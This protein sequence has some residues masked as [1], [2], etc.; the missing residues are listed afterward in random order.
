MARSESRREPVTRPSVSEA[1]RRILAKIDL[2][3]VLGQ[4]MEEVVS[5]LGLSDASVLLFDEESGELTVAVG[6]RADRDTPVPGYRLKVG[7]GMI[8][9][10]ALTR[11][12]QLANDV[13]KNPHFIRDFSVMTQSELCLPMI[14]DA[15]LLGVLDLQSR[16]P[17]AFTAAMLPGL[18]AFAEEAALAVEHATLYQNA[19]DWSQR[20]EALLNA[21]D[22]GILMTDNDRHIQVANLKCGELLGVD[23]AWLHGRK[24]PTALVERL[25]ERAVDP[26]KLER[27]LVGAFATATRTIK[28]EIDLGQ[29]PETTYSL[30]STPV[31]DSKGT[32][33][34]RL[35]AIR[36][37]SNE[38]R[39]QAHLKAAA[40]AALALSSSLD[41]D[42]VLE[43]LGQA[44]GELVP[45]D[46]LSLAVIDVER[47]LFRPT[48]VQGRRNVAFNDQD[49][50]PLEGTRV[51]RV[52]ET[53]VPLLIRDLDAGPQFA[54]DESLRA[55][56]LRCIL[57]LPLVFGESCL[58]TL[59][60]ASVRPEAYDDLA[61][62]VLG[63]I[64]DNLAVAVNNSLMHE[65]VRRRADQSAALNWLIR[66]VT[67]APTLEA[68][69]PQLAAAVSEVF[70]LD[71]LSLAL[72]SDGG[73]F[74]VIAAGLA[75]GGEGDWEIRRLRLPFAP[76]SEDQAAEAA[77]G[78]PWGAAKAARITARIE[79]NGR[80]L[81]TLNLSRAP[82]PEFSFEESD[83]LGRVAAQ[84]AG[85]IENSRLYEKVREEAETSTALLEVARA[86]ARR[87]DLQEVYSLAATC[88]GRA[89]G[90]RAFLVYLPEPD[91]RCS[92]LAFWAGP[93]KPDELAAMER[94]PIDDDVVNLLGS[95]DLIIVP[96]PGRHKFK[97]L[98]APLGPGLVAISSLKSGGE[99]LGALIISCQT[100]TRLTDKHE[101]MIKG[102]AGQIATAVQEAK[103]RGKLERKVS[104]LT[105][106]SRASHHLTAILDLPVLLQEVV[107]FLANELGYN[108]AGLFLLDKEAE[109]IHLEAKAGNLADLVPDGY[110]QS[111]NLGLT[112]WAV[113]NAKPLVS[114]GAPHRTEATGPRLLSKACMCLPLVVGPEVLGVLDLES[115]T[116]GVFTP[117]EVT[118]IDILARQ[119]AIAI[120]N[121]NIFRRERELYLSAVKTLAEAVDARDHHTRAH[122]TRVAR[123]AL[124]IAH[125]LDLPVEQLATVEY[126]GLLHDIGKIGLDDGILRKKG[127]LDPLERAQM[128]EHPTKGANILQQVAAFREIVPLVKHHHEWFA[129]GGYPDGLS[130]PAIPLGARVLAVADA[131]DAMTTDRPYRLGLTPEEAL[132]RLAAGSGTQ[133]DP[134]IVGAFSARLRKLKEDQDPAYVALA[135][136]IHEEAPDLSEDHAGAAIG[137]ILPVHGKELGILYQISLET[138]SLLNLSHLMHRILSILY[139]AMGPNAYTLLLTEPDSGDLVVK[140]CV[141]LSLEGQELRVQKGVGITGW[142]AEH[143]LPQVIGD[144]RTDARYHWGPNT[145]A[146]SALA[147][148]LVVEGRTIG[149]LDI[150]SDQLNAF[151]RDDLY[152]LSAV[153]G[154]ISIAIEVA[155]YHEQVAHAATHDGLTGTYNHSY[156]YRRL[157]EELERARRESA[158]LAVVLLD[159]DSLKLVNDVYGHLAGDRAL[160]ELAAVVTQNYRPADTIARY[161]GDEFGV[162]MPAAGPAEARRAADRLS[163]GISRRSITVQG[164]QFSLPGVTVGIAVYPEDGSRPAELVAR[165]DERMY[166]LKQDKPSRATAA[167]A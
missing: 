143:G 54:E 30:F 108:Y 23:P 94:L 69:V 129:G 165:A 92:R 43:A 2:K 139:D 123:Y 146:R 140:A 5:T 85:S 102:L 160:V 82:G 122:S 27:L 29:P 118:A 131:F 64:A 1:T 22:A 98:L 60:L 166:R 50:Q 31:L 36:D 107:A 105:A 157:E 49:W 37:I 77:F 83:F 13:T 147:V 35:T 33:A 16:R 71:Y 70:A 3:Q 80:T 6:R 97:D 93:A 100:G 87:A 62:Q 42:T 112:G 56:G 145:G 38:R 59:N 115:T 99:D 125:Q 144:V 39:A 132:S 159:V 151:S 15:R 72:S 81:G 18:R 41:L 66:A 53:K 9:Q 55:S 111:V 75:A 127:I 7:Q 44:I 106:I 28:E 51:E 116:P 10:A 84:L 163:D 110:R 91:G 12:I 138:R 156:F 128:M 130:G 11:K 74:E 155:R 113:R 96:D 76:D 150:E 86:V 133:F 135:K 78:G 119:L 46:R 134:T 17:N 89:L 65:Q 45:Y 142:V 136:K 40:E 154:Q 114:E 120:H 101:Q 67:T 19:K 63:P 90:H 34:G 32:A 8:G 24:G 58:G 109:E 149:V 162:I 153:A 124:M 73:P 158:S 14:R 79:F 126:A 4:M 148:P 57:C 88:L 20:L 161:G 164:H 47:R 95:A 103:L 117:D 152:L 21:S 104:Q 141:G 68:L 48:A 25:R 121:A 167:R 137:R 26:K 61:L 52:M